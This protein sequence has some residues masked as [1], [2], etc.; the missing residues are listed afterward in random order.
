MIR[1]HEKPRSK[2]ALIMKFS[3]KI[4]LCTGLSRF[5]IDFDIV[6]SDREKLLVLLIRN[7]AVEINK[8]SENKLPYLK[9]SGG[10]IR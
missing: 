1:Y 4:I 10:N 9:I 2:I 8:G 7:N 6:F 5:V 3:L